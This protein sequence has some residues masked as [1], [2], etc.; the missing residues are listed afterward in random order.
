[1]NEIEF[2]NLIADQPQDVRAT[3]ILLYNGVI[4]GKSAY[5]EDASAA[6][7]RNWKAAE[8]A[9][10]E[11]CV[12]I[13]ATEKTALKNIAEVLR[14]LKE[15]GWQITKTSLYRHQTEGKITPKRDGTYSQKDI[16]KYAFNFLKSI[17]TGKRVQEKTGELQQKK[18]QLELK[19]L[20]LENQRR[21]L[22]LAKE[23]GRYIPRELVEIELAGRA[24]ILD[25]G[26][27]HWIVT[28]AAEWIRTVDGDMKKIGELINLMN[29]DLD[30]HINGYAAP[31]EFQV[32]VDQEEAERDE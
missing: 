32:V 6:N 19:N 16:D 12:D 21:Q 24:G 22:A 31:F 7:L 14:Y 23:S 27:K 4:Q 20:E 17:S 8:A 3:G 25:A 28:R 11:F 18:L 5:K 1:M 26:F 13:G 30:E 9:L 29:R 10:R 15:A 2:Q